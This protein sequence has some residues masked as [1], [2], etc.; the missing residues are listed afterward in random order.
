MATA[1]PLYS[2]ST[3]G[4]SISFPGPLTRGC[5]Y[6]LP[7]LPQVQHKVPFITRCD[8]Q[9]VPPLFRLTPAAAAWDTQASAVLS[10]PTGINANR[11]LLGLALSGM[12]FYSGFVG[13]E[14]HTEQLQT[15]QET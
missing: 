10:S 8:L 4:F 14:P 13:D 1:R 3:A 11:V 15:L 2:G 9:L 6:A 12:P 5:A 7:A